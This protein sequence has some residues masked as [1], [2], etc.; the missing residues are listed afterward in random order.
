MTP[1]TQYKNN[2]VNQDITKFI[3]HYTDE[4]DKKVY[5]DMRRSKGYTDELEELS[6][7]DSG[8]E[9]TVLLKASTSKKMRLK[10]LAY[11]QAEYWYAMRNRGKV[12]TYKNYSIKK[13]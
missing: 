4:S 7:N 13:M 3:K 11:S 12:F 8:F 6:R 5:I 2:P 9:L 10:V 1:I